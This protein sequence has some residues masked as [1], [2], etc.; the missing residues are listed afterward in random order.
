MLDAN[1]S[2]ESKAVVAES[3]LIALELGYN[4]I[5]TVHFLLADCMSGFN[6]SIKDFLFSSEEEFNSFYE[7]QRIGELFSAVDSLPLTK[8]QK[9]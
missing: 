6:D 3:R 7:S 9:W 5:S 4:Y 1:F 8:K 2:A